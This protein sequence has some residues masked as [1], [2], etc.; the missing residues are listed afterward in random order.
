MP[1]RLTVQV[2]ITFTL[3][4]DDDGY[5]NY[6][7]G[8]HEANRV[9]AALV[10]NHAAWLATA[11]SKDDFSRLVYLLIGKLWSEFPGLPL[12]DTD[13]EL[14]AAIHAAVLNAFA[15]FFLRRGWA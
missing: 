2:P 12:D 4:H 14:V 7:T 10:R 13:G 1:H 5:C 6:H 8:T 15:D 9:M 3:G 11:A